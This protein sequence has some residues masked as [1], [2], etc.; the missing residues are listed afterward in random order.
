MVAKNQEVVDK[1]IK[2]KSSSDDDYY[3]YDEDYDDNNKELCIFGIDKDHLDFGD[4]KDCRF[5]INGSG[6]MAGCTLIMIIFLVIRTVVRQCNH[7]MLM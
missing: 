2:D 1:F 6:V 7:H 3:D 5:I 4:I